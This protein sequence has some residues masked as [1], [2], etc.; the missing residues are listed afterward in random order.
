MGILAASFQGM[1]W[2]FDFFSLP[3]TP[4]F[5]ILRNPVFGGTALEAGFLPLNEV[6]AKK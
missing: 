2:P 4:Y 3:P 1:Q 6:S 5:S